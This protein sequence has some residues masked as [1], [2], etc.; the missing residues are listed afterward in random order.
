[1]LFELNLQEP[2]VQAAVINALGSI[3][4]TAIAAICAGLVGQ[5][6]SGRRRLAEKLQLAHADIAFLLSVEQAHCELHQERVGQSQKN[7][8][9]RLVKDKGLTWSG[10]FTPG[11]L[12]YP[13]F[14]GKR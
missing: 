5:Q 13:E 2:E 7:T 6:I 4:T 12:C 3:V 10:K 8:I 1:M 11:R 9:R 14:E